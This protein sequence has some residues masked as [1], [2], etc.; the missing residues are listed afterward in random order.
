MLLTPKD[1]HLSRLF[2][3]DDKP[4]SPTCLIHLRPKCSPRSVWEG[5]NGAL[6]LSDGDGSAEKSISRVD[7][8]LVQS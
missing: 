6:P 4:N 5:V 1:Y 3:R 7:H 2:I 8:F